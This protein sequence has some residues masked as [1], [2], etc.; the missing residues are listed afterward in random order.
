MYF[1]FP[2]FEFYN[3]S[4]ISYWIELL[5]IKICIT[6]AYTSS[7]YQCIFKFNICKLISFNTVL[8]SCNNLT[9]FWHWF[10]FPAIFSLLSS[11]PLLFPSV[12]LFWLYPTFCTFSSGSRLQ[13]KP[14][15]KIDPSRQRGTGYDRV[16]ASCCPEAQPVLEPWDGA[17][18]QQQQVVLSQLDFHIAQQW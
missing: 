12:L 13:V 7:S 11:S 3:E 15:K 9:W 18:H 6:K 16:S 8:L 5:N 14:S 17:A 1:S 2:K 4:I 10:T